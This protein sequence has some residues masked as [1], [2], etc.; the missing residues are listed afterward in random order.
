MTLIC[1]NLPKREDASCTLIVAPVS[2]LSSWKTH[3]E[4]YVKPGT[5]RVQVIESN[6][7][8]RLE[9]YIKS[10]KP[11]VVLVSYDRVV[12]IMKH[13]KHIFEHNFF[14]VI[15]DG[16]WCASSFP[17]QERL[18]CISHSLHLCTIPEAHKV[19]SRTSLAFK[20]VCE[21]K[22]KHKWALTG[23][24]FVNQPD[25]I[26]SLLTFLN[27]APLD[28]KDEFKEK[29]TNPIKEKRMIGLSRLRSVVSH[30]VLRRAKVFVDTGIPPKAVFVHKVDYS[31]CD[32]HRQMH[33]QLYHAARNLFIENED[34][35]EGTKPSMLGL[36]NRVRQICADVRLL[37]E[38]MR[39]NIDV[40][41]GPKIKA[42]IALIES[43][44]PNEK[45]VIFSEWTGFLD[46]IEIALR[47]RGYDFGRLDGS[48][49]ARNLPSDCVAFLIMILFY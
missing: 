2:V 49:K 40:V 1:A 34:N 27:V 13:A 32:V 46:L 33:N 42:L 39:S 21:I 12:S 47:A 29:V 8:D 24:P 10:S 6:K 43:L 11:S 20:A 14:R 48:M 22:A 31:G 3:L 9:K 38:E 36:V 7:Y 45:A 30:V 41:E 35:E 4:T 17:I 28:N 26:A 18:G 44:D 15:L 19:R 16:K 37:P 5:F 23:S 25:D